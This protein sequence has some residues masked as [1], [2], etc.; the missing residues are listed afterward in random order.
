MGEAALFSPQGWENFYVIVGST[1]GALIGLQFVVLTLVTEAG[2]L[3]GSG[4]TMSAFASPNVVHF[5]AALLLSAIL[6]VPWRGLGPPGVA[7]ALVGSCGLVY[8]IAVMRR[9]LRQRDYK[10]V[11]EDWVWHAA[12]PMIAYAAL[13]LAGLEL[14]RAAT[15]AMYVVGGSALLLVFIGIHN[16]WDTVTYVTLERAREHREQHAAKRTPERPAA[17]GSASAGA[18]AVEHPKPPTARHP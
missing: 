15:D 9:A 7:I 1:A 16:A 5:C 6:S 17:A 11:L 14:A 8:S 4:E 2:L 12:L 13:V 18:R 3:R 10:P